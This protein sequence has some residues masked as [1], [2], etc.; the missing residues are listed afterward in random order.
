MQLMY[1]HRLTSMHLMCVHEINSMQI[2]CVHGISV[3]HGAYMFQKKIFLRRILNS[4]LENY[5]SGKA[6]AMYA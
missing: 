5:V 2:A 3:Q 4:N 1:V 6:N